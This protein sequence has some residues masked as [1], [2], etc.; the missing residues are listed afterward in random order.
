MKIINLPLS[1][2]SVGFF[3]LLISCGVD[4][5]NPAK[6][7]TDS[8]NTV[9]ALKL[10]G[11]L[12]STIGSADVTV[13][14]RGMSSVRQSLEVSQNTATGTV[15]VPIG[16]D[17]IFVVYAYD[18]EGNLAYTGQALGD[19]EEDTQLILELSLQPI[20]RGVPP[21]VF[22][23]FPTLDPETPGIPYL[24]LLRLKGRASTS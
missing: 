7:E 21:E 13:S 23:R 22:Q 6:T 24:R 18:H 2:L 11:E 19:V 14:G 3:A 12:A 1:I 17:R 15:R 5:T 20:E 9:I 4:N 8:S 16:Q 10:T